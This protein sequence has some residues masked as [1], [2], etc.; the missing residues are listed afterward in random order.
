MLQL[1]QEFIT[2]QQKALAAKVEEMGRDAALENEGMMKELVDAEPSSGPQS[3]PGGGRPLDLDEL[4]KEI[5]RDPEEVIDMN[6]EFFNRKFSIQTREIE[7]NMARVF[8]REGDRI[9]STLT[10]GPHDR[11]ADQ[12]C[13]DAFSFRMIHSSLLSSGY[14]RSLEV[15]GESPLPPCRNISTK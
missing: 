10:A 14:L 9:I 2:P 4:R 11:I 6:F 7:E 1:F 8:G 15:H 12:V 13:H 5:K 3:R